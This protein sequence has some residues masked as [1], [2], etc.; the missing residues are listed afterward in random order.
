MSREIIGNKNKKRKE[1]VHWWNYN[2]YLLN[3][4]AATA[5]T[6]GFLAA[7]LAYIFT[8]YRFAPTDILFWPAYALIIGGYALRIKA[9]IVHNRYLRKQY[10]GH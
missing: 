8:G 5:I 9:S 6:L 7:A 10:Y 2:F 4:L 1:S 3:S